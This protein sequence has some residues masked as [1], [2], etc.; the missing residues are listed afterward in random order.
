MPWEP[1]PTSSESDPRPMTA[2]LD[3][4]VRHMG[5]PSVAAVDTVFGDWEALVGEQIAAHTTPVSVRSGT[6]VV[7]VDDP[8]WA[9]QIRFL[10]HDLLARVGEAIGVGELT[11]L[12]VRVQRPKR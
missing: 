7:A 9:T 11:S 3:R 1:L 10:E 4:L 5:G 2:S 6:L 12:Q 8:A